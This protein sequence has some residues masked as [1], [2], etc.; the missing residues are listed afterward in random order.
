M[1]YTVGEVIHETLKM[2]LHPTALTVLQVIELS[3]YISLYQSVSKHNDEMSQSKVISKDVYYKRKQKNLFSMYA[4]VAGF[5]LEI[6]Y[7]VCLLCMRIIGRKYSLFYAREL[8]DM[9]YG[10]QFGLNTTI[11]ILVSSDMRQKLF[12]LFN[13]VFHW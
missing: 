1:Q 9:F 5:V 10:T 8:A 11:Q 6:M 2:K 7:L 3:C 12:S 13:Q 4:Q